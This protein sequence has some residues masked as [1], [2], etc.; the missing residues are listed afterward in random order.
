MMNIL[1]VIILWGW[2]LVVKKIRAFVSVDFG[3]N[4]L[5]QQLPL[6]IVM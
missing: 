3:Y 2:P 1:A 6:S 4:D 5:A